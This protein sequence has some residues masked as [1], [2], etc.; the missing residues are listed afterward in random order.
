MRVD[1]AEDV[2]FQTVFAKE[3]RDAHAKEA[4]QSERERKK[5]RKR[6]AEKDA[7]K[8]SAESAIYVFKRA[9][10]AA[11]R[12]TREKEREKRERKKRFAF[13]LRSRGREK[14]RKETRDK[15]KNFESGALTSTST[16]PPLCELDGLTR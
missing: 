2:V 10:T 3:T 13:S 1:A 11:S 7:T 14:K 4:R 6:D 15:K 5:E 9:P 16:R 12:A 8:K